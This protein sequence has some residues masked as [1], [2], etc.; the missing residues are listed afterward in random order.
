MMLD[1][2][3]TRKALVIAPHP[4]DESLGC[5][6]LLAML[7]Q[8]NCTV[9]VVFVT[10]GGASHLNSPSWS[11]M[12]LAARRQEEANAALSELGLGAAA[13]MFLNLRDAD[14]PAEASSAWHCTVAQLSSIVKE[15]K[16]DLVVLPW[17]RDPHCDHRASYRLAMQ[18]MRVQPPLAVLEYAIWLDELGSEQDQPL[19]SEVVRLELDIRSSLD[20]KKRA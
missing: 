20:A 12:R 1:I 6:G 14:M 15:L 5:G 10:D 16:P 11:R 4:D 8:R 13:R 17:R 9:T 3:Q 2:L 18:A 19:P 7:A